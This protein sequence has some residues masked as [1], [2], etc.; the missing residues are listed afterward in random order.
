LLELLSSAFCGGK[1]SSEAIRVKNGI[2]KMLPSLP[3][4]ESSG[5]ARTKGRA[6]AFLFLDLMRQKYESSINNNNIKI[7]LLRVWK[8]ESRKGKIS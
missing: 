6:A 3:F 2:V 8:G 7:L 5:A 1:K 4:S